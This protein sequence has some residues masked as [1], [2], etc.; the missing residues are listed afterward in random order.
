VSPIEERS[1]AVDRNATLPGCVIG[2]VHAT[3]G[4]LW[5][6]VAEFS[7]G[8]KQQGDDP[9]RPTPLVQTDTE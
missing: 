7:Y 6:G 5:A 4:P 8:R 1:Q 3:G 2:V 9:L